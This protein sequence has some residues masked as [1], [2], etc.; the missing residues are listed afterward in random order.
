MTSSADEEVQYDTGINSKLEVGVPILLVP[1][2][3]IVPVYT[4]YIKVG[5]REKK[6]EKMVNDYEMMC[7][8]SAVFCKKTK[9][10]GRR[11]G[12]KGLSILIYYNYILNR[13]L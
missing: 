8:S 12:R 6:R 9:K 11:R 10:R 1:V 13:H 2:P 3:I 4:V 7:P 5:R